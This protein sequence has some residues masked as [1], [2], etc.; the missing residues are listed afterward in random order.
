[1]TRREESGNAGLVATWG[2]FARWSGR[3]IGAALIGWGLVVGVQHSG[4]FLERLLEIKQVTVEGVRQVD[5]QELIDLVK[6]EPGTPLHHVVLAGIKERLESHP[7]VKEATVDRVPF[8]ELR[9]SVVERTPTAVVRAGTENYLID[10][11]GH[12][13]TALSQGDDDSLPLVTGVDPKGL[14]HGHKDVR[15]AIMSG[16]ELA[17]L[18]GQTFEGRLQVNAADPA[19]LVASIRGV[20]FHFGEGAIGDQWDRF[21]QIRPAVRRLD[22]DGDGDGTN[23]VDL[24]YENRVV[25]R[26]RG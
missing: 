14:L 13:L 2:T 8:H 1:V 22:I 12:V 19:N 4:P 3:I 23:E 17:K 10:G 24:R 26:E 18:V 20:R 15:R 16:I 11:E 25:V 21:Q 6:L 9:I 5:K 7:W